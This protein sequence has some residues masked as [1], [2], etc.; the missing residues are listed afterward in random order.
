MTGSSHRNFMLVAAISPPLGV[1]AAIVLL[2]NQLVGW[3]EL[4]LFG[5]LYL[6]TAAGISIGYHRLLTHRSY[7]AAKSVRITLALAGTL[8]AQGPAITWAAHH[9]KHHNLADQEGDPHSPHLHGEPG[10]KGILKGFWH[11]HIGWLFDHRLTSEPMRYVPDLVREKEMRWI[12]RH[13]VALVVAGIV[14]PGVIAF[15]ITQKP[16]ALLTGMLWGGIVRIFLLDHVTWS[17]NSLGHI[18]GRRRFRTSDKSRNLPLLAIP[19]L[20][21]GFHNNHH[22]FPNS[23]IIGLRR[24]EID[25]GYLIICG[26]ERLG[27]AWDVVRPGS[28]RVQAKSVD[29]PALRLEASG[30]APERVEMTASDGEP[31][32]VGGEN[33][34]RQVASASSGG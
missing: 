8:A 25:L 13:F 28:D 4:A 20:G 29:Q 24:S 19:S 30:S 14:L 6:F 2:W 9:R 16:L 31:A 1:A 7:K 26:L 27:L 32:G 22:A 11:A 12:S 21:E 23:A 10:L 34:V 18:F 3:V 15:A 33:A 5:G 17:I